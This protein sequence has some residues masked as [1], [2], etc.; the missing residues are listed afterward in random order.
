[1]AVYA[2]PKLVHAFV[3]MGLVGEFRIVL[4]PVTIGT[5]TRRSIVPARESS[6]PAGRFVR[7]R[8][9]HTRR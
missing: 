3:D 6:S 1:M 4:H 9:G 8:P 5:G 2:S 7:S